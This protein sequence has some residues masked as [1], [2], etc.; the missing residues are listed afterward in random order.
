MTINS[1]ADIQKLVLDGFQNWKLR[2]HVTTKINGDLILFNYLPQAQFE[3][4]WTFLETVSRGLI[5]DRKTGEVVARP[6]LDG[7][8]Y[9]DL[10]WKSVEKNSARRRNPVL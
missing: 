5:L 3:N 7:K 9:D 4:K 8:S 1:I 10:V 2:G 6:L